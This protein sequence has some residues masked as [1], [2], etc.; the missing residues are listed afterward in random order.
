MIGGKMVVC[1]NHPNKKAGRN[2]IFCSQCRTE[3]RR[4]I[5]PDFK[6]KQDSYRKEWALHNKEYLSEYRKERTKALIKNDPVEYKKRTRA[7]GLWTKYRLTIEEFELLNES[8]NYKC[9]ICLRSPSG[10]SLFML[11][12]VIKPEELEDFYVISVT[13]F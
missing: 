6:S 1:Q 4:K 12:I 13:G 8:Q 9:K 7:S 5:D 3:N 10:N 2:D 11:I